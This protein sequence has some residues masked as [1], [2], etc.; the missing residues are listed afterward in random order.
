MRKERQLRGKGAA[1]RG[2]CEVRDVTGSVRRGWKVGFGDGDDVGLC[3]ALVFGE[4]L[5]GGD[6]TE[7]VKGVVERCLEG[8]TP[9]EDE[10]GHDQ[11]QSPG[12][13]AKTGLGLLKGQ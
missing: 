4:E 8:R 9:E 10:R 11:A 3:R 13:Q 6:V 12:E 5:G 2:D 1:Q 7:I